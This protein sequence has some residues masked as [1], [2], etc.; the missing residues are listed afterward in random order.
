MRIFCNVLI[1]SCK[2]FLLHTE[3]TALP[4]VAVNTPVTANDFTAFENLI[5]LINLHHGYAGTSATA[6]ITIFDVLQ[7]VIDGLKTVDDLETE[8]SGLY[9][10]DKDQ[11]K[12]L[13]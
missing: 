8:F 7:D 4:L 11:L 9:G 3:L 5:N 13:V 12:A 6:G 10:W 2:R 1:S